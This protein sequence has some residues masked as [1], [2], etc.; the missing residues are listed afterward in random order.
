MALK[1]LI[2]KKYL[3]Y[4]YVLP[5]YLTV[6]LNIMLPQT[7]QVQMQLNIIY[8]PTLIV[9]LFVKLVYVQF[10]SSDNVFLQAKSSHCKQPRLRQFHIT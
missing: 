3:L 7:Q 4:N 1:I 8:Q 10:Y 6:A 5:K 2:R 9:F